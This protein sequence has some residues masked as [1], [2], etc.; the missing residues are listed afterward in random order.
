MT[1]KILAVCC[2]LSLG[3]LPQVYSQNEYKLPPKSIMDIALAGNDHI[4]KVNKSGDKMIILEK[5][6]LISVEELSEDRVGLAGFRI[7]TANNSIF[8][9]I[10]YLNIALKDLK[11]GKEIKLKNLPEKLRISD[12]EWSPDNRYFAFQQIYNDRVELW[13]ADTESGACKRLSP[14]PISDISGK[15]FQWNPDSKSIL[16]QFIPKDRIKPELLK[17]PRG[18]VSQESFNK[19]LL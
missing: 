7:T 12:I 8:N 19:N 4:V 14:S 16:A 10:T 1:N 5:A 11:S 17:V 15:S 3:L 13:L 6:G 18:P 2:L 9:K